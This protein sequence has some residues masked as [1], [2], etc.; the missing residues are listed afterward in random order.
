[1][2]ALNLLDQDFIMHW[3]AIT[4][5]GAFALCFGSFAAAPSPSRAES[6]PERSVRIITSF[7]A[8]TGG[9]LSARLY[10]ERLAL[11]WGKPVIVE[12]KPGADGILAVTAVIGARDNHT[13]LYT[14]GGPITT[15]AFSHDKLPYDAVHD[16]VPISS[17]ADVSIAVSIPASL[18]IDSLAEFVGFARSQPGKLNWGATPGALDYVVPSFLKHAGLDLTHVS[19]REIVPALQDLAEGRIHLYVSALASQLGMVNS[20]NIKVIAVTNRERSPLV[21]AAQTTAEAGFP[22]LSLEGF[23][24]FFCPREMPKDLADRIGAGIRAVGADPTISARLASGGLIART[25]TAAEFG[26]IIEQERA[27][28]AAIAGAADGNAKR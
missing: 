8:G 12:N 24:G 22:D 17:G 3:T 26:E 7:P 28:V 18:K 25:N 1:M 5:L 27:K 10:A 2:S 11:R 23:L 13:L 9:D 6:W 16:L 14:N 21:S 19:Y 15:N 4:A 20:G